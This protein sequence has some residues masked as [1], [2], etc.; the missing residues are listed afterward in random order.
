MLTS[1]L[2]Y[3]QTLFSYVP[4]GNSFHVL[5]I[6]H[7]LLM[8]GNTSWKAT[9]ISGEMHVN[10]KLSIIQSSQLGEGIW[11]KSTGHEELTVGRLWESWSGKWLLWTKDTAGKTENLLRHI[12][13]KPRKAS[14]AHTD[15][16]FCKSPISFIT[17]VNYN[18]RFDFVV[19]HCFD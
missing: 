12:R 7:R 9:W 14:Q 4:D 19:C 10:K 8:S 11:G 1:Q 16:V 2:Q 13:G 3:R 15:L 17:K 6:L 18:L 5:C